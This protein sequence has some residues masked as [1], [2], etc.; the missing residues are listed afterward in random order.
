MDKKSRSQLLRRD[1]LIGSII[2]YPYLRVKGRMRI[3]YVQVKLTVAEPSEKSR[4]WNWPPRLNAHW[5]VL[6]MQRY[7]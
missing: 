6:I 2:L 3:V 1:L 7:D 5:S 4:N